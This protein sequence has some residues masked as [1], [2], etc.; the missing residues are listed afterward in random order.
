MPAPGALCTKPEAGLT[1]PEGV[2]WALAPKE[3]ATP[4]CVC[5]R[6]GQWAQ[7]LWLTLKQHLGWSCSELSTTAT[8]ENEPKDGGG[9]SDNGSHCVGV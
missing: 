2:S 8:S 7:K 3:T 5:W 1:W 9:P 4:A 6:H